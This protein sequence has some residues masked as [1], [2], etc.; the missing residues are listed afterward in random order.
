[1][2]L[3]NVFVFII[4]NVR[5]VYWDKL[6][7]HFR[8]LLSNRLGYPGVPQSVRNMSL[9]FFHIRIYSYNIIYTN[10]RVILECRKF[11]GHNFRYE[12]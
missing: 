11:R 9:L 10:L 1:V 3:K 12:K 4:I 6:L 2:Q 5:E 7:L 8:V